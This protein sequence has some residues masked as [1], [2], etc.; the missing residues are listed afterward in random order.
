MPSST[1][2]YIEYL[3][4]NVWT[5]GNDTHNDVHNMQALG[6]SVLP[7]NC[8]TCPWF[9]H[10]YFTLYIWNYIQL[11]TTNSLRPD[12]HSRCVLNGHLQVHPMDVFIGLYINQL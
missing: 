4:E 5:V 10:L 11:M 8:Y 9:L 7:P 6:C 12:L 1:Y 3:I 2:H